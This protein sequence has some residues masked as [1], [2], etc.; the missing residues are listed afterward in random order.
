MRMVKS[1]RSDLVPLCD[2]PD[3]IGVL[4]GKIGSGKI[5]GFRRQR[6]QEVHDGFQSLV[7]H[8]HLFFFGYPLPVLQR[9]VE[10]FYVEAEQDQWRTV[11]D[12]LMMY[13]GRCLL[14]MKILPRYRPMM[15]RM[16][17]CRP[18]KKV[19]ITM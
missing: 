14:C 1:M 4:P 3:G 17:N 7:A 8:R 9:H 16:D 18:P 19:M 10:F 11:H 13:S 15:P 6:R 2:V 5:R 12:S